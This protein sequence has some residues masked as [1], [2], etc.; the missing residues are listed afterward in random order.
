[1]L[2]GHDTP[3]KTT[4]GE[5]RRLPR[6]MFAVANQTPQETRKPLRAGPLR[7]CKRP[8]LP[9]YGRLPGRLSQAASSS[10]RVRCSP[11]QGCDLLASL[12]LMVVSARTAGRPRGGSG[13]SRLASSFFFSVRGKRRVCVV[14]FSDLQ[15]LAPTAS[16]RAAR[17]SFSASYSR[18]LHDD[19]GQ[20]ADRRSRPWGR[21]SRSSL[22]RSCRRVS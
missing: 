18:I 17:R 13:W 8:R 15:G 5:A 21:P 6:N 11:D 14:M 4:R 7:R 20:I 1:M 19:P 3:S 16:S 9:S 12:S 10:V 2:A 22:R